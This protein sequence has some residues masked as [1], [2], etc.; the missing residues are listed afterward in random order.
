[1]ALDL[2]QSFALKYRARLR[3]RSL[4]EQRKLYFDSLSTLERG[5]LREA[6]TSFA[7]FHF[8]RLQL[9][10]KAAAES[11][12]Q[13]YF[14]AVD[15]CQKHEEAQRV[16]AEATAAAAASTVAAALGKAASEAA[17]AK[18]AAEA[19][20]LAAARNHFH[21]QMMSL[22]SHGLP[23]FPGYVPLA[24]TLGH[25]VARPDT[26][27]LVMRMRLID[28]YHGGTKANNNPQWAS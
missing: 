12:R 13:T 8:Q 11:H 14:D 15:L 17:A 3:V 6:R 21:E 26:S 2:V 9:E 24:A 27:N 19:D 18:S 5:A 20:A 1:L 10:H 28:Y 23:L 25:S 7:H 22:Q 16:C 4:N